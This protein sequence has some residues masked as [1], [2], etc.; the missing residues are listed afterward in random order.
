M[1]NCSEGLGG[2]RE[3]QKRSLRLGF[4]MHN[5]EPFTFQK[6]GDFISSGVTHIKPNDLGRCTLHITSVPKICVFGNNGESMFFAKSPNQII[7]FSLQ[8]NIPNMIT[9]W[10]FRYQNLYKI[11]TKILVKKK[12]HEMEFETRRSRAAANCRQARISSRVRSGKSERILSSLMP[13]ARYSNTSYTVMRVPVIQGLPLRIVEF[14]E[15]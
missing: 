11:G 13:P 8:S 4:E 5:S 7:V 10:E 9:F 3:N 14:T 6:S 12:F 2:K 1:L 15:I